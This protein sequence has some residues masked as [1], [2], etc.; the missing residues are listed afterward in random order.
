MAFRSFSR[1]TIRPCSIPILRT[2]TPPLSKWVCPKQSSASSRRPASLTLTICPASEFRSRFFL[3]YAVDA[4]PPRRFLAHQQQTLLALAK[5]EQSFVI[6]VQ[7]F[8]IAAVH[9]P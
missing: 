7:C 3:L 6:Q 1:P 5:S 2:N 9:V 4:E 8:Q